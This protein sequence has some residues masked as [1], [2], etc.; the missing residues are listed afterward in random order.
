MSTGLVYRVLDSYAIP[1]ADIG[2]CTLR[3]A[4]K[5]IERDFRAYRL[6]KSLFEIRAWSIAAVA[7]FAML[8]G[9]E[10]LVLD[11]QLKAA[12]AVRY[13]VCLPLLLL[14]LSVAATK[15]LERYVRL[16]LVAGGGLLFM[17]SMVGPQEG[18]AYLYL[19]VPITLFMYGQMGVQ[20][21][22]T[23]PASW[24]MVFGFGV[25]VL[26]QRE[27]LGSLL[28][29]AATLVVLTNILAMFVAYN[30]EL[31]IRRSYRNNRML[32]LQIARSTDLARI[33]HAAKDEAENG[34]R[35]KSDFLAR[36]SHELRTPLNAI[37]GFSEI[38]KDEMFGP[39]ENKKYLE[40]LSDSH[41]GGNH[42]LKLVN[43]ILE[44][45]KIEAGRLKLDESEC[46]VE[47]DI[48]ACFSL[49][50]GQSADAGVRLSSDIGMDAARLYA[51]RRM[52]RQILLDLLS[53]AIKFSD[54]GGE[55][56]V[57]SNRAKDG[58]L[59]VPVHDTGTGI[60][61]T[62]LDVV[63]EPFGR[64]QSADI[65]DQRGTGLG[66]AITKSLVERH[67][68][69][70]SIDSVFGSGTTVNASFPA[71]RCVPYPAGAKRP[72]PTSP[73]QAPS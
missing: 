61:A 6:A 38:M 63:L 43:D 3:F 44:L 16:A 26:L 69:S 50:R 30:H 47:E 13:V 59:T 14:A 45:S 70:L 20:L 17:F 35:T 18:Q 41:M 46:D 66:L 52:F 25:V 27:P 37:I 9:F 57:I 1:G 54:E 31:A 68:G 11:E 21:I 2:R 24:L 49:V 22:H 19:V 55:V 34:N 67:G 65:Q 42:L 73:A 7:F 72:A 62:D 23:A 4:D 28:S 51:D 29:A 40:Y 58:G 10:W 56:G 53:N 39:V 12:F 32:K 15:W 8:G 60:K 48:L 64:S 33:A 71:E 5:Q 36:M